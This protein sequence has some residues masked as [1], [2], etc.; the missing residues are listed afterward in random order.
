MQ[1]YSNQI[2]FCYESRTITSLRHLP[3]REY[4]SQN[5]WILDV[6]F[7]QAHAD[8]RTIDYLTNLIL[9]ARQEGIEDVRGYVHDALIRPALRSD[10]ALVNFFHENNI[11]L[12]H[13][14]RHSGLFEVR[15]F[16]CVQVSDINA[17]LEVVPWTG[18]DVVLSSH[19]EDESESHMSDMPE[20]ALIP[21]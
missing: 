17:A 11:V 21:N 10:E 4:L 8:Q 13:R 6:W 18:E 19:I 14:R 15:P 20:L 12:R 2:T 3:I 1:I 9:T 16:T 5:E 7:R